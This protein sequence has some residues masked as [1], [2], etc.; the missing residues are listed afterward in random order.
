MRRMDVGEIVAP[1]LQILAHL[2]VLVHVFDPDRALEDLRQVV[3]DFAIPLA[4]LGGRDAIRHTFIDAEH[5]RLH[6]PLRAAQ[7]GQQC[8]QTQDQFSHVV[9]DGSNDLGK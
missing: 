8:Q 4:N 7:R 2:H 3:G 6:R 9:E 5:Q 1:H